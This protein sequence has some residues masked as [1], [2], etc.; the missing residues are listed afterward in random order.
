MSAVFGFHLWKVAVISGF[1]PRSLSL[2]AFVLVAFVVGAL[3]LP[4]A[5]SATSPD[6]GV[7][8]DAGP[9]IDRDRPLPSGSK[10]C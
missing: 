2:A 1:R 3:G 9:V 4:H 7:V 8:Q 10:P 6:A 5:D